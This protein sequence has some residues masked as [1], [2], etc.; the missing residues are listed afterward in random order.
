MYSFD[1][2]IIG[3]DNRQLFLA[4][5]LSK[6]AY[7]VCYYGLT[8]CALSSQ[9]IPCFLNGSLTACSS[10]KE[11][12]SNSKFIIGPTPLCKDNTY[13]SSSSTI[14]IELSEF[15][16]LWKWSANSLKGIFLILLSCFLVLLNTMSFC[17]A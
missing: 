2:A 9:Y 1:F 6:H 7:K 3:G 5:L 17:L 16:S 4:D 11:A 12:I 10:L 15:I 13:V 8:P 14:G